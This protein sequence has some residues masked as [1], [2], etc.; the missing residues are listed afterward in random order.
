MIV[1]INIE[2]NS[3]IQSKGMNLDH[4]PSAANLVEFKNGLRFDRTEGPEGNG[5]NQFHRKR[6]NNKFEG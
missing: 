4:F 1:H 5:P 3:R 6:Q 2:E